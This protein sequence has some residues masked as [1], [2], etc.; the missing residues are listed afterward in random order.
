MVAVR[1]V[2]D[3]RPR[4]FAGYV[5]EVGFEVERWQLRKRLEWK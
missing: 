1:V 4:L 2:V 5:A 3:C